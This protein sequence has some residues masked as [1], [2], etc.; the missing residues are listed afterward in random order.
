[1][2]GSLDCLLGKVPLLGESQLSETT[3]TLGSVHIIIIYL[4]HNASER[5]DEKCNFVVHVLFLAVFL[6]LAA[7]ASV[8]RT[9]QLLRP[10]RLIHYKYF[11]MFM[12][13]QLLG[14]AKMPRTQVSLSLALALH[15]SMLL[16]NCTIFKD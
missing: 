13:L 5:S 1:V 9:R 11:G 7:N 8:T 12:F 14:W 10:F 3:L 15:V 16:R 4:R 6:S 2:Y